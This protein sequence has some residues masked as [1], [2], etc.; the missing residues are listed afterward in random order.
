MSIPNISHSSKDYFNYNIPLYCNHNPSKLSKELV[1]RLRLIDLYVAEGR[2]T[3]IL[4]AGG[5]QILHKLLI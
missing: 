1:T 4:P 2:P 5:V 3:V